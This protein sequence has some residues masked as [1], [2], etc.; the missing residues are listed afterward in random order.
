VGRPFYG[1]MDQRDFIYIKS[2]RR[3]HFG[4]EKEREEGRKV[5]H[6]LFMRGDFVR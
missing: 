2:H 1:K 6:V 4:G 3:V 5:F